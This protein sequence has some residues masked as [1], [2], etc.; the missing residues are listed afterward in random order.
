MKKNP[1]VIEI[2]CKRCGKVTK[3]SLTKS[4]EY[5][6][7]LCGQVN[8]TVKMRNAVVE[9]TPDFEIENTVEE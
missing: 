9:F 8:K 5:T 2:K 1:A 7:V 6:C 4:G 3:H